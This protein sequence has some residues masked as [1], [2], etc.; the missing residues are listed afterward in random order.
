MQTYGWQSLEL[1][2]GIRS[3]S[4]DMIEAFVPTQIATGDIMTPSDNVGRTMK[5]LFTLDG[6]K[7]TVT[8]RAYE[9]FYDFMVNDKSLLLKENFRG[10]TGI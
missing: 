1:N 2:Y 4:Y 10:D 7:D 3:G 9:D 6:F 5:S 8:P